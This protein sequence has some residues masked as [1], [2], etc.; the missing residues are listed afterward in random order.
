MREAWTCLSGEPQ[1]EFLSWKAKDPVE[2]FQSYLREKGFLSQALLQEMENNINQEIQE[3]FDFAE[4]SSF[5]DSIE[6]TTGQYK[7]LE[8]IGELVA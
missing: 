1:A 5:P 2:T 8:T 7:I 3:A 6:A 4:Q